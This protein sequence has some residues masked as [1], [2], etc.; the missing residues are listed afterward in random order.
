M[1][2][3]LGF[4]VVVTLFQVIHAASLISFYSTATCSNASEI[5]DVQFEGTLNGVNADDCHPVGDNVYALRPTQLDPGCT[6]QCL[7]PKCD[8]VQII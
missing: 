1:G 8:N 7:N 2:W 6:S 3:F 4:V 5:I